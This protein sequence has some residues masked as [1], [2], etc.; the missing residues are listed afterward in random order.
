MPAT[1]RSHPLVSEEILTKKK[2][3]VAWVDKHEIMALQTESGIRVYSG[4]CPHQGGPI[5]EGK[6]TETTITCPWH[7]CTFNLEKGTCVDYGACINISN[8]QLKAIPFE[9][10]EGTVFVQ[11]PE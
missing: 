11:L 1:T 10:K 6:R 8:M 9:I 4:M 3:F 5:S 2:I 7:G